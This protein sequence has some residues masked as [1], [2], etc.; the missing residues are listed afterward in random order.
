MKYAALVIL[1]VLTTHAFAT[2]TLDC[3]AK[4]YYLS[5]IVSREHGSQ[6]FSLSGDSGELVV[7]EIRLW[8]EF[9]LHW[10][11]GFG[12][13]GNFISFRGKFPNKLSVRGM[14]HGEVGTLIVNERELDFKCDWVK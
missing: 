2:D 12:P 4:P 9:R 13:K 5:V 8:E 6:Q 10:L 3:V 11:N 1:V 7:G 14:V